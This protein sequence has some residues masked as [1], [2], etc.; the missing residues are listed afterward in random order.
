[1]EE[2]DLE[3]LLNRRFELTKKLA[4]K[5]REYQMVLAEKIRELRSQGLA[6]TRIKNDISLFQ[7]LIDLKAE[8]TVV[9]G[10]IQYL[11]DLF[12]L[13]SRGSEHLGLS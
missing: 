6:E 10:E 12:Y 3:G 7:E 5:R 1:M 8:I 11:S 9:E 2:M 13:R 4:D